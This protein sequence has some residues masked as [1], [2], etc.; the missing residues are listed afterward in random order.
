MEIIIYYILMYIIDNFN[1]YDNNYDPNK[2]IKFVNFT[3]KRIIEHFEGE[4]EE[5]IDE[6]NNPNEQEAS[7]N[8]YSGFKPKKIENENK[9]DAANKNLK[10]TVSKEKKDPLEDDVLV[11][12]EADS[13]YIPFFIDLSIMIV[14]LIIIF[15]FFRIRTEE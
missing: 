11:E 3:D 4:Q 7:D 2:N 9:V 1:K 13:K 5:Q 12:T 6:S 14:P 10:I 8:I 15:F